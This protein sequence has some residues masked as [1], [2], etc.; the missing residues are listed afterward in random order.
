MPFQSVNPATGKL[1]ESFE[2][3]DGAAL[4][5]AL[6]RSVAAFQALRKTSFEER[7]AT[8]SAA[9]KILEDEKDA[10]ARIATEEMGK[11]LSAAIAEVEKCAW[12]CRFYA[13][14]A[15]RMLA[16]EPI[17]T[18]AAR[19][20]VRHLPLGP[21]L[22][23]MPWNFPY[24]Q[25]FRFAAPA[26]MAGNTGLLKHA[27]NVPR[28]A[29]AIETVFQRAGFPEGA[30]TTLLIRSARVAEVLEDDRV[31][32][33]TL[34]GS[35][36]A[37]R[38]VGG[39][40]GGQIKPCVLE[41]GGS[42][43]FIVMPSADLEAAVKAAV[44][45]RIINNGQSCIAAKRFLVHRQVYS[46]FTD[47]FVA[48]FEELR[49]GD[50]MDSSTK[51]GPLATEEIRDE[52]D[53]Q[54]RASLDAGAVRLT[55]AAP[56]EG[57]GFFYQPGILA[58]VPEAAPAYRDEVFG[59]VATLVECRDLDEAIGVGN[60]T[61]FGLGSAIWTRDE[62]EVERAVEELDAGATFVNSIVASDPR[63][64]FGGVKNS[65]YGRELSR[66]GIRAFVNRKTVSVTR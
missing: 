6:Q 57:P 21:I 65:G 47:R 64:P 44:T 58:Q 37:G 1:N 14:H 43:P 28:S 66:D 31:R 46:A 19:S 51:I 40:A 33:A 52:I 8:M 42:D 50:P 60:A 9:A 24:W 2:E 39:T 29:L 15:E 53:A 45:A 3:L 23:V 7:A 4:E 10:W 59:P 36:A 13:D 17:E 16:D 62:A 48:A 41:L 26:L 61:P 54:V 22:A 20:F 5:Q 18:E 49:V 30:F 55:G 25:V 32:A 11:T 63:L 12:V 35:E 34:T 27:A 38:A 56:I